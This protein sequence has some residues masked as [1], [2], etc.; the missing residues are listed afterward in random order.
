MSIMENKASVLITGAGG[1]V[2]Q[3]L[4]RL[5][6]DK[7]YG[8][9]AL[10]RN[11]PIEFTHPNLEQV[12]LSDLNAFPETI[13]DNIDVVI[14]L[15]AHVHQLLPNTQDKKLY[16]DVNLDITSKL[17]EATL[18]SSAQQFIYLS[19]IKV[20][21][22][23]T[24][25]N[26]PFSSENTP[27]PQDDYAKSKYLA[28]LNIKRI[29]M[30]SDVAYTLIRPPLVY[31]PSATGNFE[32]LVKLVQKNSPLL[33]PLGGI[34][35][36]RSFIQV[37]YLAKCIEQAILNPA[38]YNELLLVSDGKDIS[39][40]ELIKYLAYLNH[41]KV[42]LLNFPPILLKWLSKIIGAEQKF[43]KLTSNLQID[44]RKSI[45]LLNQEISS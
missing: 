26:K 4:T 29:F 18:N 17:A 13:L 40:P 8:V 45:L 21:G 27:D 34:N 37:N 5:L 6:V 9:R 31:G 16:Y 38:V 2:G 41:K 43:L 11:R 33:W 12:T 44:S 14:H 15:A 35:N 30:Q 39:T 3:V 36:K 24:P 22:E 20:N 28:E 7:G 23:N 42:T 19:T 32:Q 1:F 10:V 25:E